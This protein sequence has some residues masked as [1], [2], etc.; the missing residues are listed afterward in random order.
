MSKQAHATNKLGRYGTGVPLAPVLLFELYLA[1][2]Y[3]SIATSGEPSTWFPLGNSSSR[4]A[5]LDGIVIFPEIFENFE[6]STK[7][8]NF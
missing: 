2:N 1:I 6:I 3:S 7:N 5:S 4:S 8:I